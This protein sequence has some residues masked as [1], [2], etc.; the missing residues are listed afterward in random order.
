MVRGKR[1]MRVNRYIYFRADLWVGCLVGSEM[2]I[3]DSIYWSTYPQ[4]HP[5]INLPVYP[6]ASLPSNH[7]D[8]PVHFMYLSPQLLVYLPIDVPVQD[9]TCS[10]SDSFQLTVK[11]CPSTF[12]LFY[13]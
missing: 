8:L 2:C 4:I 6:H 7:K 11:I 13:M 5:K 12:L 10:F 1:S 3:R 9:P